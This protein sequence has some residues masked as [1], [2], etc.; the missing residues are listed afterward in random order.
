MTA[1]TL[2]WTGFIAIA[3]FV[4]MAANRLTVLDPVE[5]VTLNIT[6]P[7][8]S[9]LHDATRPVA[10][11]VNNLTDASGLSSENENLR[12]E[13]ER[14]T[15]ELARAREAA[16]QQQD[17]AGLDAVRKQFPNDTF[18]AASVVSRFTAASTYAA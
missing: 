9:V 3:A 1:R 12:A 5:N 13:N 11:W 7:I 6:A 17:Q 8:Q 16:V 15:N 10:G 14:L 4:L 2:V 18:V